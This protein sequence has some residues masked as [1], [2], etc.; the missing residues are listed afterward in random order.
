MRMKSETYKFRDV[1]SAA[2]VAQRINNNYVRESN[3]VFNNEKSV[4]ETTVVGNKNIIRYMMDVPSSRAYADDL[5]IEKLD[6][7]VTDAD[8]EVVN[9]ICEYIESLAMQALADNLAGYN[10]NIYKLYEEDAVER[11]DFGLIASIPSS[12][13]RAL[14]REKLEFDILRDCA[15]TDYLGKEGEKI[16]TDITIRNHIYSRNYSSHIYTATTA[17]NNLITFWS[18]KG[19]DEL[20]KVGSTI[21]IKA[22]VKRFGPSNFYDGI[23]ETQLNYVKIV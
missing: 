11:Y 5:A 9:E 20:G 15:N 12:V 19:T 6:P 21:K 17:E 14:K 10:L 4:Y 18:Q 22:K 2:V 7:T 3:Y 16:V 1:L 13:T 23:K 8:V